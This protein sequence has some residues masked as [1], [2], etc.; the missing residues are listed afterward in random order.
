MMERKMKE[1]KVL[2]VGSLVLLLVGL[3]PADKPKTSSG[4]PAV[5]TSDCGDCCGDSCSCCEACPC[6][7]EQPAPMPETEDLSSHIG[8]LVTRTTRPGVW[9]VVDAWRDDSGELMYRY[10]LQTGMES[11]CPGGVC[12]QPMGTYDGSSQRTYPGDIS[13]HLMS[14]NHMVPAEQLIGKSKD[15][16]EAMHDS[17]HNGGQYGGQAIQSGCPGGVCPQP[18]VRRRGLFGWRR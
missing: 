15:E 17:L 2:G 16:L 14:G 18:T 4:E 12:P 8:K 13:N 7:A 11:N 1:L 10:Q 9:K 5:V 3:I 6:G